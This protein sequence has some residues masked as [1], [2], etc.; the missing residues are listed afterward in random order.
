MLCLGTQWTERT[1]TNSLIKVIFSVYTQKRPFSPTIFLRG[2]W[3]DIDETLPHDVALLATEAV[4]SKFIGSPPKCRLKKTRTKNPNV[5]ESLR[6]CITTLHGT[7]EKVGPLIFMSQ[8]YIY[9]FIYLCHKWH[10][11]S[12]LNSPIPPF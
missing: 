6:Q 8:I 3:T 5:S 1:I 11:L 4:P 2:F 7:V 9:I 10:S 12:K